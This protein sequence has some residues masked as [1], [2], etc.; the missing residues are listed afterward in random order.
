MYCTHIEGIQCRCDATS[1][2]AAA[3]DA[4]AAAAVEGPTAQLTHAGHGMG[5]DGEDT[6]AAGRR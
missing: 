3:V 6:T 4:A 2:T 5:S 1:A